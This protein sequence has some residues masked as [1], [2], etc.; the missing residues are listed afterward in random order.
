[1]EKICCYCGKKWRNSLTLAPGLPK[2]AVSHGLCKECEPRVNLEL[3]A[4]LEKM[5]KDKKR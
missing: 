5:K 1:M 4:I 3:D 2:G